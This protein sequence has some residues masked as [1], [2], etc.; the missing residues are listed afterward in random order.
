MKRLAII[1]LISICQFIYAQDGTIDSTFNNNGYIMTQ[2]LPEEDLK[3]SEAKRVLIQPDGKILVAGFYDNFGV[4]QITLVRYLPDGTPDMSF[5]DSSIV[6]SYFYQLWDFPHTLG[7]QS[8]GKI[9]VSGYTISD[10][11]YDVALMRFNTDG[12]VDSSF[13]VNGRVMTQV[14]SSH[15]YAYDMVILDDDK[16]VLTGSTH[17][18]T[19]VDGILVKYTANGQLDASFG[20]N[21]IVITDFTGATDVFTTIAAT[22][23]GK[24]VVGGYSNN[25]TTG[26]REFALARY[27][28]DGTLDPSFDGDG[29]LT[30]EEFLGQMYSIQLLSQ[31]QIMF[32]GGTG[33]GSRVALGKINADGTRDNNFGTNGLLE[34]NFVNSTFD[35]ANKLLLQDD[36]KFIITGTT[37][38][39]M[40][41]W[42]MSGQ[43]FNSDG[44]VD[45]TFGDGGAFFIDLSE[46]GY[47]RS[48]S[49][50][51]APDGSIYVVGV[52]R[53]IYNVITFSVLKLNNNASPYT[54]IDSDKE[55]LSTDF[56][57]FNNYP[58]PFNPSTTIV[59]ELPE[60]EFVNLSVTNM[61]GQKVAELVNGFQK[62]GRHQ[63][64]FDAAQL[65][66]GIYFYNL[67][68]KNRSFVRKMVLMK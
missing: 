17:N 40:T 31:N 4:D 38:K 39:D 66:S 54:S 19:I 51:L 32:V 35:N 34:T 67:Q 22:T 62:A 29:L 2:I 14:G 16:I 27:N 46:R 60:S 28:A 15:D 3:T 58:N 21:G 64:Q 1:L 45:T 9:I 6:K 23:D 56:Q 25:G 11:D 33:G 8:D 12:S 55:S 57:L 48:N 10:T 61:L 20:N 50:V 43:R 68:T 36:G 65:S 41:S 30:I 24:I 53:N 59:Y 42:V 26:K 52:T 37:F 18:S 7:L 44:S 47:S 13:G 49:A 63:I 5:G